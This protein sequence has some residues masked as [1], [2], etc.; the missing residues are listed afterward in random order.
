MNQSHGDGSGEQRRHH[1]HG[2]GGDLGASDGLDGAGWRVGVAGDGRG[3]WLRWPALAPG[4]SATVHLQATLATVFP[5][6]TTTPSE[7]GG[8]DLAG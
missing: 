8:G 2:A 6:G 7:Y 3:E 1:G 4:A 5:V